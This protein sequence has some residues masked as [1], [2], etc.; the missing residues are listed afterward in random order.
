MN[1]DYHIFHSFTATAANDEPA[2]SVTS[3]LPEVA[4]DN[5]FDPLTTTDNNVTQPSETPDIQQ[6]RFIY[7]TNILKR[8]KHQVYDKN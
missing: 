2:P 4:Y 5:T 3:T 7:F 6:S 8:Q 1:I